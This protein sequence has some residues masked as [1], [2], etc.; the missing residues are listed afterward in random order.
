MAVV[1]EQDAGSGVYGMA[2]LECRL[3]LTDALAPGKEVVREIFE[4]DVRIG[5]PVIEARHEGRLVKDRQIADLPHP[6]WQVAI[7]MSVE[8]RRDP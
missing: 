7:V 6:W 8:R 5:G 1:S 2:S 4:G 3:Q